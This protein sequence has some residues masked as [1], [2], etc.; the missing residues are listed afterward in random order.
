MFYYKRELKLR[1]TDATQNEMSKY[2]KKSKKQK[3]N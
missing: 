2:W 3:K 1:L